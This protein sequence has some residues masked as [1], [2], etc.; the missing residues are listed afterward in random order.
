MDITEMSIEELTQLSIKCQSIIMDQRL[1]ELIENKLSKIRQEVENVYTA[2][3]LAQLAEMTAYKNE[4]EQK[5]IDLKSELDHMKK[6]LVSYTYEREELMAKAKQQQE[7]LIQMR[8]ANQ[9]KQEYQGYLW[10]CKENIS[11]MLPFIETHSYEAY[12]L[13]ICDENH[14]SMIYDNMKRDY[15]E[16][17]EE[18][19]EKYEHLINDFIAISNRISGKKLVGRQDV[20]INHFYEAARFDKTCGSREAGRIKRVIYMGLEKNGSVLTNCKS[21]VEV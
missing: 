3:C 2:E 10:A 14:I 12:V 20:E 9:E 11:G 7:Q 18:N 5:N 15:E 6:R 17:T 1:S 16:R 21:L 19:E 13:S 8:A 4:L